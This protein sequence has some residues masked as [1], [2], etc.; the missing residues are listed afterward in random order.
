MYVAADSITVYVNGKLCEGESLAPL[1]RELEGLES[2]YYEAK[3][4]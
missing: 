1:C 3:A 2:S 4:A